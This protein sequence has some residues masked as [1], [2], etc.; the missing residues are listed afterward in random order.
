MSKK[1]NVAK[2]TIK[3]LSDG[4]VK[5][6]K[7]K[8]LD[9]TPFIHDSITGC[10]MGTID[11]GNRPGRRPK[12]LNVSINTLM[13]PVS[14]SLRIISTGLT[15]TTFTVVDVVRLK[16]SNTFDLT[17][18]S[19]KGELLRSS[20]LGGCYK[21]VK[22][23]W[24]ELNSPEYSKATN[25]L[26][27]PNVVSFMN[28]GTGDTLKMPFKFNYLMV[29]I[30]SMS[31]L[32]YNDMS[33]YLNNIVADIM[34]AI[35]E[36]RAKDI[37][38]NPFSIKVFRENVDETA[39]LFNTIATTDKVKNYLDSINFSIPD[40][41][42]F[43]SFIASQKKIFDMDEKSFSRIKVEKES[44]EPEHIFEVTKDD[45]DITIVETNVKK[46]GTLDI[47]SIVESSTN[48]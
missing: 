15:D 44:N 11:G 31:R 23:K 6:K 48:D 14:D 26:Y 10:I 1:K 34:D 24:K 18:S 16:D 13:L 2:T 37:V 30:P 29:S 25:F 38:I 7:G 43:V 40:S 9:L 35:I 19:L 8:K 3:V 17:E 45:D 22:V 20:T 39:D 21:E 42:E 47:D 12:D 46:D 5:I 27:F 28:S 41:D 32:E 36:V 4:K 33:T